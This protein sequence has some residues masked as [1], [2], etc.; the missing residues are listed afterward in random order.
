M[1]PGHD[2]EWSPQFLLAAGIHWLG[3][4]ALAVLVGGLAIEVLVLPRAMSW[5]DGVRRRLRRLEGLSLAALGVSTAGDLMTRAH[6]MAGGGWPAARAALPA[7]LTHTHFGSLWIGRAALL[8]VV[9]GF[10]AGRSRVCRVGAF[11]AAAAIALTTTLTG[12]AADQGDIT[13]TVAVDWVHGIATTTWAGGLMA[14][15]LVV[16]REA[17]DWPAGVLGACMRRFSRLA[18]VCVAAVLATGLYRAWVELESPV[19]LVTTAY[20]RVL[21]VKL[22]LVLFLLWWGAINRYAVL[23]ALGGD[24]PIGPR[25]ARPARLLRRAAPEPGA[26]RLRLRT[27][28]AREAAVAAII[29]ACTAV[30]VDSTPPV[31]GHRGAHRANGGHG[32]GSPAPSRTDGTPARAGAL[33][34]SGVR[35]P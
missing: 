4:V 9:L 29:F 32:G 31:H 17:R 3:F 14:L 30:L 25:R 10:L 7:V 13:A 22:L 27:F 15:A 5:F 24:A 21:G 2:Q 16:L 19:A 34:S 26:A 33:A 1:M 6:T 12:H 23:P 11:G 18:G 28:V 8:A 20:G 35:A